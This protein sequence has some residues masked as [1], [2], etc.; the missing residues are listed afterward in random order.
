MH[1]D[2]AYRLLEPLQPLNA[3]EAEPDSLGR[4]RKLPHRVRREN[5]T[6]ARESAEPRSAV[7]CPTAVA[8][9]YRHRLASVETAPDRTRHPP[10]GDLLLER[11]GEAE[12]L[13]RR[14]TD[15]DRLV[16][17]HLLQNPA[18]LWSEGRDDRREVASQLRTRLVTM[19]T[20]ARGVP[21]DVGENER[22]H[23]RRC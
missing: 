4:A 15:D 23:R 1:I 10:P 12:R 3:P 5:L 17:P 21:P 20:R 14:A 7:Q 11:D 13:P 6:G 22:A 2:D 16:A 9:L 8:A 18:V 19:L